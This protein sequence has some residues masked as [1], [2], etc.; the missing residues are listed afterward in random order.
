MKVHAEQCRLVSGHAEMW[1]TVCNP[2]GDKKNWAYDVHKKYDTVSLKYQ[3]LNRRVKDIN[4]RVKDMVEMKGCKDI[5]A[6]S[7]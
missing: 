2:T 4:R 7:R 5:C 6:V 3:V 1:Y